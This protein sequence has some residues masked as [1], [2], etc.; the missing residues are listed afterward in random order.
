VDDALRSLLIVVTLEQVATALGRPAEEL[1]ELDRRLLRLAFL[2]RTYET[3]VVRDRATGAT[4]EATLDAATGE[5]ADPAEL[6]RRDRQLG[7]NLGGRLSPGLRS[8][9]FRHPELTAVQ[10]AVTREG[11]SD[12]APLRAS[13]RELVALARES[14]VAWIELLEDPEILD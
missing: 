3:V 2:D 9:V 14:G 7:A 12:P 10:V 13:V 11:D 5:R 8:L 4:V 1:V 6:L